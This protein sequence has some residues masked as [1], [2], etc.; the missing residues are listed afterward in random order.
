MLIG[1]EGMGAAETAAPRE[2][3]DPR[4]V[5]W[6]VPGT[7]REEILNA[8]AHDVAAAGVHVDPDELAARLLARER[9]KCT[10][11]SA[12]VAIPHTRLDR[13]D[14]VVIAVATTA[15]PVD[16]AAPDGVPVQVIFLVA[17]PTPYPALILQALARVSRML[18]VPGIAERL[19]EAGS[20]EEM[21]DAVRAAETG[22]PQAVRR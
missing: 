18:R 20:R 19:R 2:G 14:D 12:G 10:A 11:H 13:L 8:L 1:A 4:L 22:L 9:E 21:R 15:H 17:G 6:H 5:F 16:F 3:I 7:T